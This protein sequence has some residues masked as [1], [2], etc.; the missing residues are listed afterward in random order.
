[1]IAE[2]LS[3]YLWQGRCRLLSR[4]WGMAEAKAC[5]EEKERMAKKV[6]P[7]LLALL[8]LPDLERALGR[9]RSAWQMGDIQRYIASRFHFTAE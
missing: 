4:A 5:E 2:P 8:S 1:M 6:A 7:Q 3:Y 9:D